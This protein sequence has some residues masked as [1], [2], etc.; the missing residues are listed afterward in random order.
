VVLGYV[1]V[2]GLGMEMR[3]A[4]GVL[5][6]GR[7][8]AIALVVVGLCVVVEI[9]SGALRRRMMGGGKALTWAE[10]R[11]RR[12]VGWTVAGAVVLWSVTV[13][14]LTPAD[15]VRPWL[16]LPEI[17]SAFW[18]PEVGSYGLGRFAG[19]LGATIVIAAAA[20]LLA[21]PASFA[22]GALAARSA[23]AS[24]LWRRAARLALVGFRGIPELA[25]GIVLIVITGLGAQAGTLALAVAGVGLLGKLTADSLEEVP[26]GPG[27]ALGAAGAGR[28]QT[29]AAATL[30]QARPALVGHVFYLL[31]TNIRAATILGVVG[32]GG[33]GY[34]LLN[35]A[36]GANYGQVTVIVAMVVAVVWALESLAGWLR[37][38]LA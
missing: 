38:A 21:L 14:R 22:L 29:L 18:P 3:S 10:S 2:A 35:A 25:L 5:D 37:R 34:Y 28:L 23:G 26:P 20:T 17:A 31:D 1:G 8:L 4:F 13:C 30:P 16:A 27:A 32:G 19:A 11:R 15:L 6:Y 33:I 36:Q 9:L 24:A 12:A 7:G